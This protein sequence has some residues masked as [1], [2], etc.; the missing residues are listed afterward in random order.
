MKN[1]S[2]CDLFTAPE[3]VQYNLIIATIVNRAITSDHFW[4]INHLVKGADLHM[5]GRDMFRSH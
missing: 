3:H 5:N 1:P 4:S 2:V